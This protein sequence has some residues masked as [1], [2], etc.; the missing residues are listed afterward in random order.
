M[1]KIFF[2]LLCTVFILSCNTSENNKNTIIN[3]NNKLWTQECISN[4]FRLYGNSVSISLSE[5]YYKNKR[6]EF[7]SD[8]KNLLNKFFD[9]QFTVT[10]QTVNKLDQQW[11]SIF[12]IHSFPDLSLGERW[13]CPI[14]SVEVYKGR[15]RIFSRGDDK[16][17]SL[18]KKGTCA[19]SQNSISSRL[20]LDNYGLEAG[21][22]YKLN[23]NGFF[24]Y[25]K[26][27]FLQVKINDVLQNEVVGPNAFNDRRG[28]YLKFGIYKPTSWSYSKKYTYVYENIV[29]K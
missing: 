14:L 23:I 11:H 21:E 13:R 10:P 12:Q 28:P 18:L 4:T 29:V 22:K 1:I 8:D 20:I 25:T 7:A 26:K 27:G 9:I 16:Q 24:S 19:S 15:L 6:C 2:I 3:V 5:H 17:V